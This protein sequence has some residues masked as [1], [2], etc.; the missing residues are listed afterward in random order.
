MNTPLKQ[1]SLMQTATSMAGRGVGGGSGGEEESD[2]AAAAALMLLL[3][4]LLLLMLFVD[5]M[6]TPQK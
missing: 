5:P 3:L 4:L 2:A 1:M 6:E